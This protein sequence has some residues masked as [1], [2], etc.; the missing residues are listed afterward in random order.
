[1]A[2]RGFSPRLIFTGQHPLDAPGFGLGGFP[3]LQ[4]DCPAVP[5]PLDHADQVAARLRPLADGF[6]TVVVQ[7][8]TSSALGVARA[9]VAAN[10]RVAHVEAGL[11]SHDRQ[12]PWPEEGF[13]IEIDA[14]ADLLFAPT[15]LSA[16]NLRRE[17][18]RGAVHV[19][20]NTSIDAVFAAKAAIGPIARPPRT[21]PALLVTCHRRESWGQGLAGVALALRTIATRGQATVDFLLHPNPE[22]AGQVRAL[23]REAQGIRLLE[24]LS[25][26]D[27]VAAMLHADAVLT[28]S[29]GM[30]EECAALG[31]PALVLR[32]R[33]ER[34]EAIACGGMALVGLDP[35]RI[36]EAVAN[37]RFGN[38]PAHAPYGDG[39]ASERIASVL[40]EVTESVPEAAPIITKIAA[41]W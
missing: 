30:Q 37:L 24:P 26:R 5:D 2:A 21:K 29:G 16:A 22:T 34:P 39:R 6:E 11:R 12:R 18:V 14:A 38:A 32:E 28:D 40:A 13:R 17:R 36:V 41:G 20:G 1:M 8:D 9:A 15:E 33:T 23:L 31:V 3:A 10:V 4:L 7:G 19:T 25:Y 35:D 27:T